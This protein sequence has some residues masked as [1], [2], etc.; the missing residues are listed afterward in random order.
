MSQDGMW[1]Q[2]LLQQNMPQFQ[3]AHGPG[4]SN[5]WQC[6][7]CPPSFSR[8]DEPDMYREAPSYGCGA[9]NWPLKQPQERDF[10]DAMCGGNACCFKGDCLADPPLDSYGKGWRQ[11]CMAAQRPCLTEL[12]P[13]PPG[14]QASPSQ[15][16]PHGKTGYQSHS[17]GQCVEDEPC[18]RQDA[19]PRNQ[20]WGSW[21]PE[22]FQ[23]SKGGWRRPKGAGP[24]GWQSIGDFDGG[25]SRRDERFQGRPKGGKDGCGGGHKGWGGNSFDR[26][27][28]HW[29]V[30]QRF[31]GA[32]SGSGPRQPAGQRKGL[33][34]RQA[35]GNHWFENPAPTYS[36][37]ASSK[38]GTGSRKGEKPS[39]AIPQ[40]QNPFGIP[41]L[42]RVLKEAKRR[43]RRVEGSGLGRNDRSSADGK[44][45]GRGKGKRE[46]K[47]AKES[48]SGAEAHPLR[49]A[50][51]L[52]SSAERTEDVESG[53][54]QVADWSKLRAVAVRVE[55]M[56]VGCD[57]KVE[58]NGVCSDV[59]KS[60]TAR[61]RKAFTEER[62]N[63]VPLQEEDEA[64]SEQNGD[65]PPLTPK[66][67]VG[68]GGFGPEKV[69]APLQA[70]SCCGSML[71]QPRR[72]P[73]PASI[74]AV[75]TFQT[76]ELQAW[77]SQTLV[78][79]GI[80]VVEVFESSV[81][82]RLTEL[83]GDRF[84]LT[85][86][87][88]GRSEAS[89]SQKGSTL[90]RG[91]VKSSESLQT[92]DK[93]ESSQV[94][95]AWVRVFCDS[96]VQESMQKG[97]KT[98]AAKEK[99]IWDEPDHE[100]LG[101]AANATAKE[102]TKAFR[103][104][105]LL[106]HPDKETDPDKKDA[107]EDMMKRLNLAKT[108]MLRCASTDDSSAFD[109][110]GDSP[111]PTPAAAGPSSSMNFFGQTGFSD[112]DC[113]SDCDRMDSASST[114][115]AAQMEEEQDS[116]TCLRCSLRIQAP[117]PP[118]LTVQVRNLTSLEM[119]ATGLPLGG[120]VEV[121][122]LEGT[123]WVQACPPVLATSTVLKFTI[124][125][126]EEH[127]SYDFRLKTSLHMDTLRL[128]FAGFATEEEDGKDGQAGVFEE[129]DPEWAG[130]Q[131]DAAEWDEGEPEPEQEANDSAM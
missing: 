69:A 34:K 66:D 72:R 14:H 70:A 19:Y 63:L 77:T 23:D 18:N 26:L 80:V 78:E 124:G 16:F 31:A 62:F 33:G 112:S 32:S 120:M 122:R 27:Q 15:G 83:T 118:K 30:D 44:G 103:Q 92:I 87:A 2:Q 93:L 60:A 58:L 40:R 88:S 24:S 7:Q 3:S 102:I 104:K 91:L 96:Q 111:F 86:Y 13:P 110:F 97:F 89:S 8:F 17:W 121:Q 41:D 45:G 56:V 131:Q 67:S 37:S 25:P 116:E 84:E 130:E 52:D 10:S 20:Q 5:M 115:Q 61:Q 94:Y 11:Q 35:P 21:Q 95:V 98:L 55:N 79:P 12:R 125:N 109:G 29:G 128:T 22:G 119:E 1:T 28:D 108:N 50:W 90:V 4:Q 126:L 54:G 106:H 51:V 64:V 127:H 101:V 6:N 113:N 73:E 123:T 49:A 57:V 117:R 85:V 107:A 42:A 81:I 100:I 129:S 114:Q 105:S 48:S 75:V 36:S 47:D 99:T 68:E 39:A 43:L 46:R 71:E 38:K 74:S 59:T 82:L 53:E 65:E 76:E 9:S